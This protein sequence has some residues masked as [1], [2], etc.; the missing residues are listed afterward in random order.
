MPPIWWLTY[1][2]IY[3]NPHIKQEFANMS[4]DSLQTGI[5]WHASPLVN[6]ALANSIDWYSAVRGDRRCFNCTS[7][8]NCSRPDDD[9]IVSH[10]APRFMLYYHCVRDT[11]WSVI[12]SM[13]EVNIDRSARCGW[14]PN[15]FWFSSFW[16][17]DHRVGLYS[18]CFKGEFQ[19][20][21]DW[22]GFYMYFTDLS[23][24]TCAALGRT[25]NTN[26]KTRNW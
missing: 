5:S 26:Y 1:L 8:G 18:L 6:C 14:F 19:R 7:S 24:T 12:F 10:D 2:L 20:C 23:R 16:F 13:R 22:E 4:S 15:M 25:V 11:S 9:R 21:F 17:W 3:V